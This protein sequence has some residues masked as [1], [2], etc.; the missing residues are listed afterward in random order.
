MRSSLQEY[1]VFNYLSKLKA[2]F[3]ANATTD[4]ITS[5]S[6]GLN[7]GD[8]VQLT[9]SG[10]ALPAGLTTATNYYVLSSTTNTFQLSTTIDGSAVNITDAG[11]GTHSFNLK[12]K[13]VYME[14]FKI[15]VISLNT[16]N[17]AAFKV[18]LQG[19]ITDIAPD[20]NAPQSP[21]NRWDY[22]D[23]ADYNSTGIIYGDTGITWTG[24][25]DNRILEANQNGL[26]YITI[27]VSTWS[28]G[29]LQ[30][31]VKLFDNQ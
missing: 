15:A 1:T 18:K 2:A 31:K 24:T 17:S 11:T 8:L 3:T 21:T 20:F 16:A 28:A 29:N 9:N 13:T 12:G 4:I 23:V 6:H 26:S 5:N 14:D 19:A 27:E 30:C 10:G 7:N 22:M 25:D